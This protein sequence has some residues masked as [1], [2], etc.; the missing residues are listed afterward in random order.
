MLLACVFLFSVAALIFTA[1]STPSYTVTFLVQ[2]DTTGEWEQ[3]ATETS[4]EGVVT[5]PN[6][7]T[8]TDYVFRNW[9]DNTDFTGD[10]FTGEN[11]EGDM[12]VYAYFVPTEISINVT[13]SEDDVDEDTVYVRDLETLKEQ[14]EAEALAANLTFDGWYTGADY[15]TLWT[16]SSDVDVVYGR[17]MAQI[18]YDNGYETY[19]PFTVQAGTIISEPTL[20]Y[21]QKF[22]MDY[23]DIFYVVG[24]DYAVYDDNG[25]LTGYNE[26]DFT[27][28]VTQNMT[29]KVLWKTPAFKYREKDDG[30]LVITGGETR[31]TDRYGE[32]QRRN[33]TWVTFPVVSIPALVTYNDELRTV[34]AFSFSS[35]LASNYLGTSVTDIIVNEGIQYVNNIS[36][37]QVL[38]KI[39]LPNSVKVLE[40]F[41]NSCPSL[42]SL[43][44]PDNTE[45]ILDSFWK[46][47]SSSLNPTID[48]GYD[49]PITIPESVINM[50]MMPVGNLVFEDGS[51]FY[52][53]NNA[54]YKRDSRGKLL[55]NDYNVD[56]NG[57][58]YIAD[59][60]VG[61]QVGAFNGFR[62]DET[63]IRNIYLPSGFSYIGY[64]EDITGYPFVYYSSNSNKTLLDTE[65]VGNDEF[66]RNMS[67]NG[68]AVFA[69]LGAG[70]VQKIVFN[71]TSYPKGM[72]AYAFCN[73]TQTWKD[74]E[75]SYIVFKG[76]VTTGT[77]N[78]FITATNSMTSESI[79]KTL[80]VSAGGTITEEWLLNELRL[81]GQ[82]IEVTSIEEFGIKYNFNDKVNSNL[83]LEVAYEYNVT[84]YTLETHSDGTATVL[85]YDSSSAQLLE[86]GLYLVS[87]PS[88]IAVEG[89]TYTITEIAEEAFADANTLST[90][91]ISS[92]V[93]SIGKDAFKNC[94]NLTSVNITPGGLESI[95]ESAFENTAFTTIKLPLS[96]LSYVGPYAFKS[97]NLEAFLLADG[98]TED[99]YVAL[100][101]RSS[102]NLKLGTYYFA[103]STSSVSGGYVQLLKL[104]GQTTESIMTYYSYMDSTS[105]NPSGNYTYDQVNVYDFQL[106]AIAGGM[107]SSSLSLGYSLRA[108]TT[109][110]GGVTIDK[111]FVFRY[112]VMTGS[113]YYLNKLAENDASNGGIVF[114]IIK[115]IHSN[116][117]TDIDEVFS[118]TAVGS[119][120]EKETL[121]IN[122]HNKVVEEENI[123][124]CWLTVEQLS[125]GNES[126][127]EDGWWE[128]YMKADANYAEQ[129]AFLQYAT[130]NPNDSLG[131]VKFS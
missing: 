54:L 95:G 29:I 31:Y 81:D 52:I 26:V 96:K 24:D 47:R 106:Y 17:F 130:N 124:D 60:V 11:V 74:F 43:V 82:N 103:Q 19:E 67:D 12:N 116:A 68:Y 51:D 35:G 23:T 109:R 57:N 18:M 55:I 65:L 41:A 111:S 6:N 45:I 3:Y 125:S 4:E 2:N 72:S 27:Q 90:I 86:N 129:L 63:D 118:Q 77:V 94:T 69:G 48:A 39:S 119:S 87:I 76:T 49:F 58:L 123:Y 34:N 79:S 53:E 64:N 8:K 122:Y 102:G 110:L 59:D 88:Q 98:E 10:P 101:A 1:C 91:F 70:N 32:T 85:K 114:G 131:E 61:I 73:G 36:S 89:K 93:K 30:N 127:F 44:I 97:Q 100:D 7:P 92:S 107:S 33:K 20:D 66:Y 37:S 42:T 105:E 75:N 83:Y 38:Q 56:Q 120:G 46:T 99:M 21:I 78:I 5:L 15:D 9:Y 115:K 113:V 121:R 16:S 71:A 40:K 22:Y 117:F 128:G 50:S 80:T 13:K 25:T 126:I 104:C 84:G 14:Y 112:E 28:P 62:Y 108:Y